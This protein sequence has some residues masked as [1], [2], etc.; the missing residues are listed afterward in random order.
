[1]KELPSVTQWACV[2]C[3]LVM[4][5]GECCDS[6]D[7]GGQEGSGEGKEPLSAIPSGL[8]TTLGMSWEEHSDDCPNRNATHSALVECD[9]ERQEFSWS[10]CDG[11][12]S[13]LGGNRHAFVIWT[14]GESV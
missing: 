6:P 2:C 7:H 11:C 10:S 4:A 1:M 12:G 9:C 13:N 14:P 8:N 3:T 5:N